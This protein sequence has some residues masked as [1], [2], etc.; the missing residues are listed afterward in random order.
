MRC[1]RVLLMYIHERSGHHKAALALEKAFHREDPSVKCL[2]V[3]EPRYIHPI[4]DKLIH[5]TYLEII[6]KTPEV[7]E[8]LYDNPKVLK[9]TIRLR[10]AI[11]RSHSVKFK[12]LLD[13]FKPDAIVCTQAFPCGIAAEHK[14]SFGYPAPLYGV[15]T[16]FLTHSYW[17][18]GEVDRYFVATEEAKRIL[19]ENGIFEDRITVSGIP[20]DPSF[21]EKKTTSGQNAKAPVVL[22]MG[23]SQGL[24]P[25]EEIVRALD[26]VSEHFEMVVAVGQNKGLFKRL[27]RLKKL[28][29]KKLTVH[30][31]LEDVAESMQNAFLLISKPGGLTVAQALA[32][33]LPIIFIDPVPGQESK[34]ASLLLKHRA[35][36]EAKSGEEAAL[37]VSQL[38]G[39]PAKMELMKKNMALIAHPDA[40]VKI[41]KHVLYGNAQN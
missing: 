17:L 2:L 5:N 34:N 41:A 29:R 38:L 21:C 40:A 20:I 15:L 26:K 28:L 32:L 35:A 8:Y 37:F 11:R 14:T 23:G 39:A 16:D 30:A 6:R 27:G 31:Y 33:R 22:V 25:I 9:N 10:Q 24:G 18:L 12:K 13:N 3:N 36:I 1:K 7:W 4:L 19:T